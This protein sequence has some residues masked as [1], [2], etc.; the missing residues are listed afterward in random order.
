MKKTSLLRYASI[1]MATLGLGLGVAAADS[2]SIGGTSNNG[3]NTITSTNGFTARWT[4][5]S[6]VTVRHNNTQTAGSGNVGA[7]NVASLGSTGSGS[8][9][10]SNSHSTMVSGSG[11]GAAFFNALPMS[12]PSN[13]VTIDGISNNSSNTIRFNNTANLT[14][15]DNSTVTVNNTNSQRVTSGNVTL[16]NVA[17]A[18]DVTSGDVSADNSSDTTVNR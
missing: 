6:N 1:G 18:G 13:D 9:S 14:F 12:A 10:A 17:S 15:T 7:S 3:S 16:S 5:N 8:A 4:D 11:S 2:V